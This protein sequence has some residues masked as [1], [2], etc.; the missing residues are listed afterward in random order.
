MHLFLEVN[1]RQLYCACYWCER[2]ERI[3]TTALCLFTADPSRHCSVSVW[4]KVSRISQRAH[5]TEGWRHLWS[6]YYNPTIHCCCWHGK[7]GSEDG[8]GPT[9]GICQVEGSER[10]WNKASE[11]GSSTHLIDTPSTP[12]LILSLLNSLKYSVVLW[13]REAGAAGRRQRGKSFVFKSRANASS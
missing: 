4:I 6:H 9:A 8:A 13:R 3:P 5:H 11:R 10:S 12:P 1:I 7:T 2:C